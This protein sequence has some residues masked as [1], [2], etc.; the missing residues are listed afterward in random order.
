[1][2]LPEDQ[3]L[4][5]ISP[6]AYEHPADRAATAALKQIPMLDTVVRMLIEYGYERAFRQMMLANSVRIGDDQLS[7]VWAAHRA[8]LARLDIQEVPDLYMMQMPFIN[9]MAIGS[10][11]PMVVLNSGTVNQLDEHDIRTVLGHEAA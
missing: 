11:K 4:I 3:R 6:R 7:E 2:E 5:E 9:A 8:A 10:K 1:M